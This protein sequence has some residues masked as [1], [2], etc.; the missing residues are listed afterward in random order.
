MNDLSQSMQDLPW[1]GMIPVL[2]LLLVGLMLWLAGRRVLRAGM[3]AGGLVIGS[4]IGLMVA[5][6]T[7]QSI[8]WW[9]PTLVGAILFACIGAIA[10]RMAVAGT[11]AVVFG[12]AAPLAVWAVGEWDTSRIAATAE[13]VT[14]SPGPGSVDPAEDQ[15][16]WFELQGDDGGTSGLLPDPTDMAVDQFSI[17]DEAKEQVKE[18]AKDIQTYTKWAVEQGKAI[19]AETPENLRPTMVGAA[20]VGVLLGAM[21]GALAPSLSSAIVTAFGG[22]MLML[23][24]SRI[25][26]ERAGIGDW[27]VVPSSA[28][29]WLAVWV[30]LS[31]IGTIFQWTFRPKQAD[32]SED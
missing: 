1:A 22:T 15:P 31:I 28:T 19:W 23:I 21:L 25:L 12:I 2:G 8:V 18:A 17:P 27:R 11:L 29:V 16:E 20:V 4:I 26:G 5:D 30:G 7:P 10:Y 14:E 3:A 13:Q 6:W 32:N 24:G 9:I